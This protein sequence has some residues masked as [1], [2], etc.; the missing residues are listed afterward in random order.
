MSILPAWLD[1]PVT[2]RAK[3]LGG[4]DLAAIMGLSPWR[5]PFDVWLSKTG[6]LK[7]QSGET[8]W[9]RWG[10]LLEPFIAS[11]YAA[12]TQQ[13]IVKCGV[14]LANPK[15]PWMVGSPDYLA[16]DMPAGMDAKNMRVKGIEWGEPGTDRVPT[17]YLIQMQAYMTLTGAKTWDIPVLF[18]GSTFEIFKIGH[19]DKLECRMLEFAAEWWEKHVIK[20]QEPEIQD[21]PVVRS[22]IKD[23]FPKHIKPLRQATADERLAARELFRCRAMAEDTDKAKADAEAVIKLVIASSEGLEMPEGK[24]T[25]RAA[26]DGSKTDWEAV[27]NDLNA[28]LVTPKD[29]SIFKSRHTVI[30]PGSRRLL[31][32]LQELV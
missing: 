24:I 14:T 31:V 21:S 25:Y 19:N 18:G 20:G 28:L 13:K 2:D 7:E 29:L 8:E 9:Q 11:A 3:G 16:V 17:H 5:T 30:T 27:A 6:R 32:N 4:T 1:L 26:K 22:W 15:Y 12:E 10:N 23:A